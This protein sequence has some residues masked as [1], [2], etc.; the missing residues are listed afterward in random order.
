M[1][2]LKFI[3]PPAVQSCSNFCRSYVIL[4]NAGI[5]V[6]TENFRLAEFKCFSSTV[7]NFQD[8]STFCPKHNSTYLWNWSKK[9]LGISKFSFSQNHMTMLA[10][11]SFFF[12]KFLITENIF[13]LSPGH[14][15]CKKWSRLYHM[16]ILSSNN[17]I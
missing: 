10:K 3:P 11:S 14:Y 1:C 16:Q 12:Y 4:L 7:I 5:K 13:N 17:L 6:L 9:C 2:A 8:I 15:L